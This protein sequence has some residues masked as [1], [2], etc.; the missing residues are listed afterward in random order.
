[1]QVVIVSPHIGLPCP[2][3]AGL[4]PAIHAEATTN[5][6]SMDSRDKPGNDGV[7]HGEVGAFS[8]VARP[9]GHG[10]DEVAEE[11]PER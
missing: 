3:I 11:V 5:S 10:V 9:L 6:A 1:M 4:V 7:D 2:V 8:W